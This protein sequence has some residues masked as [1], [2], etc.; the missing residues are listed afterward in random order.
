MD[1]PSGGCDPLSRCARC[2][3]EFEESGRNAG[4]PLSGGGVQ[5]RSAGALGQAT[6]ELVMHMHMEGKEPE[7]ARRAPDRWGVIVDSTAG[8]P[9][10][11]SYALLLSAASGRPAVGCLIDQALAP[12]GSVAA[13][14]QG[15]SLHRS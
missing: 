7:R 1:P 11:A 10:L 8:A 2:G 6:R 4:L 3:G 5:E 15:L 14:S 13:A 12:L 9:S